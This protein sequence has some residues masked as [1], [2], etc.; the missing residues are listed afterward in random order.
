[1]R[2]LKNVAEIARE[3][4]RYANLT[5]RFEFV[6]HTHMVNQEILNF[7][8]PRFMPR[9]VCEVGS[10]MGGSARLMA[11]FPFVERVI[12]VDHWD[13]NLVENWVPGTH[14]EDWMDHMYEHFLANC[15]HT[16]LENKIYPVRA[17]SIEGAKILGQTGLAFDMIYIDGAH[18]TNI[19]YQDL[20][21][22]LPFIRKGGLFCGDDWMFTQEPENVRGAVL[23]YAQQLHCSVLY[24]GNFWWYH[25]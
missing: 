7:M 22:Y 17:D 25:F 2:V 21:N 5:A 8:L 6:A 12:C 20:R 9:S 3:D 11:A 1:M 10:W 19:V 15:L 14:P 4:P 18:A 24:Q 23:E 13:R 16:G